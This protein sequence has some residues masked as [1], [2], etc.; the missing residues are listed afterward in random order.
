MVMTHKD[1]NTAYCAETIIF[2][3]K[4]LFLRTY[5]EM[6]TRL[7]TDVYGIQNKICEFNL[8]IPLIWTDTLWFSH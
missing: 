1:I 7:K 6:I 5:K 2:L 3:K 8:S 4:T